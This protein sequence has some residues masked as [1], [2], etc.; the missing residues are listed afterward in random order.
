MK[1]STIWELVKVN[2]LYSNSN[3]LANIRKRQEKK[4]KDRFSIAKE[5]IKNQVILLVVMMVCFS[6]FLLMVDYRHYPYY[7]GQQTIVFAVMAL[8]TS[9]SA[10]YSVFYESGDTKNYVYLPIDRFSR[11]ES[12]VLGACLDPLC[13]CL[14]ANHRQSFRNSSRYRQF[15]CVVSDGACFIASCDRFDWALYRQESSSKGDFN[16]LDGYC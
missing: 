12:F 8:M 10:M 15:C 1:W 9:F 14:L 13:F 16:S 6:Y 2:I 5:M 3:Y 11:D 7:L 4:Q